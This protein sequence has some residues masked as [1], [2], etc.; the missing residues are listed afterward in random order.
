MTTLLYRQESIVF[1]RKLAPLVGLKL[2][3]NGVNHY[4]TVDCRIC[5]HNWWY[6]A[7]HI[8]NSFLESYDFSGKTIVLFAT[9]GGSDFGRTLE[10]LEDSVRG[11]AH[12]ME[13]RMLNGK[14]DMDA[15]KS[16]VDSLG[17]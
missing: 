2:P 4:A 13:G 10:E 9:S 1:W 16:W 5:P 8:I 11:T 15:L 17:L 6:V 14:Q 7:P 3:V 12:L